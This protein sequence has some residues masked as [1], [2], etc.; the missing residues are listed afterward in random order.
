MQFS[1]PSPFCINAK[2]WGQGEKKKKKGGCWGTEFAFPIAQKS[3]WTPIFG[4]A[5]RRALFLNKDPPPLLTSRDAYCENL[6][7]AAESL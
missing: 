4:M 6:S 1:L 7:L 3:S 5:E 2:G